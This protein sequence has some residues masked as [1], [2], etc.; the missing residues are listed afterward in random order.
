M[1]KISKAQRTINTKKIKFNSCIILIFLL[2]SISFALANTIESTTITVKIYDNTIEVTNSD[3]DGNNQIK[4]FSIIEFDENNSEINSDGIVKNYT[5]SFPFIFIKNES[6]GMDVV[7]QYVL[8]L[9][10]K[11]TC[12]E[13]KASYN[14]AWTKCVV[15]LGEYEGENATTN[16]E[17]LDACNLQTQQKD[18]EITSKTTE[19]LD[20]EEKEKNTENSKWFFGIAGALLGVF[21]LLIY[22][23]KIGKGNVKERSDNEFNKNQ[24]G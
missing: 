6:V 1:K 15:D 10:E 2:F 12:L 11:T 21:G 7:S 20:L 16:K 14:T 23:G 18:L 17:A 5:F 19:I 8:C 13:D 24:A 22:Q 3:Y 4:T 9:N